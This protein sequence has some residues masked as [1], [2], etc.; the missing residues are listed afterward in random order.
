MASSTF[1]D[2]FVIFLGTLVNLQ[3]FGVAVGYLIM[4]FLSPLWRKYVKPL[5]LNMVMVVYNFFCSALS[6]YT[7]IRFVI[8][9][10]TTMDLF[11]MT[12]HKDL[13]HPLFMYFITKWIE[14]LDTVFMILR[15]K[16]R[17]ISFLHVYHHCSVLLLSDLA[18]RGYR[19]PPVGFIL[20]MNS[21]VHIFLYLYYGQSALFPGQSPLWKKRLTQLQIFQF[22][23]GLAHTSC[24][25]LYHGFC[26][27]GPFYALS[28]MLLFS[29]FYYN[30]FVRQ[31]S[32]NSAKKT[33]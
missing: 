28:M 5:Q 19:W 27:Y 23:I 25:Y 13:A 11:D 8:I 10:I 21:F 17:Q 33:S 32:N 2:R 3:T 14:L 12:N 18:Y 26:L 4:V 29:N 16:E 30:A 6:L 7:V 20:C 1:A 22:V 15:H 31:R 24:G 9:F